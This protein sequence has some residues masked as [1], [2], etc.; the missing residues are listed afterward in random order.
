MIPSDDA[1][2]VL[3]TGGGSTHHGFTERSVLIDGPHA[4]LPNLTIEVGAGRVGVCVSRERELGE[5]APDRGMVQCVAH[6]LHA[7]RNPSLLVPLPFSLNP[8]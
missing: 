6:G 4:A 7:E 3:I 1:G 8:E 5:E 2:A